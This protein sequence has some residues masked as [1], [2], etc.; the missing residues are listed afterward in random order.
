MI[1]NSALF[2]EVRPWLSMLAGMVATVAPPRAG[3]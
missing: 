1:R 3:T 2:N